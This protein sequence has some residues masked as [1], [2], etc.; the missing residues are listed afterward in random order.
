MGPTVEGDA[1]EG[2]TSRSV[3]VGAVYWDGMASATS[4][5]FLLTD[6]RES[7]HRSVAQR[8][9]TGLSD[10]RDNPDTAGFVSSHPYPVTSQEVSDFLATVAMAGPG[11]AFTCQEATIDAT[12]VTRPVF[13]ASLTGHDPFQATLMVDASLPRLRLKVASALADELADQPPSGAGREFLT[14]QGRPTYESAPAWL[15]AYRTQ[16]NHQVVGTGSTFL[17]ATLTTPPALVDVRPPVPSNPV[18]PGPGQVLIDTRDPDMWAILNEGGIPDLL[19]R[20]FP[21]LPDTPAT[22]DMDPDVT[23]E[24][25]GLCL[26]VATDIARLPDLRDRLD[27]LE[28]FHDRVA[29]LLVRSP[30]PRE[31]QPSDYLATHPAFEGEYD[32]AAYQWDHTHWQQQF[33]DTAVARDSYLTRLVVSTNPA[34]AAPPTPQA[35]QPSQ[36]PSGPPPRHGFPF[37]PAPPTPGGPTL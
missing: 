31:P 14:R 27:E 20:A 23:Q 7:I 34:D 2:E 22:G 35:P 30:L 26:D 36:H 1:P 6:S 15:D 8:I 4:P 21:P 19:L 17:P 16:A 28:Y 11:T 24:W 3:W 10:T 37:T 9:H 25:M 18:S 13:L 12:D 29:R 33:L 32:T 5:E